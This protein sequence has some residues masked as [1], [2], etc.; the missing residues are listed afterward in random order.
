VGFAQLGQESTSLD[1]AKE[2]F[3]LIDADAQRANAILQRLLEFARPPDVKREPLEVNE[4]VD[5]AMKLVAHPIALM[6]VKV[7]TRFTDGLPK[8]EGNSNQLRQV[9]I[10]LMMNAAQAMES[11]SEKQLHVETSGADWAVVITVKDT[12]PGMPPEVKQR[13]FEPFFTTKPRGKGTGLG[14]SISRSII[15]EHQGEIRVESEVGKGTTFVIRLGAVHK[16][17][18]AAPAPLRAVKDTAA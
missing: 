13:L 11:S 1:E 6:G 4:M 18:P 15:E 5:S 10:N 14:L 3:K 2:Y 16:E 9:L 7:H 17:G 12:G 8:I